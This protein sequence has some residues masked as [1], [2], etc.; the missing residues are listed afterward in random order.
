MNSEKWTKELKPVHCHYFECS[1]NEEWTTYKLQ[2]YEEVTVAIPIRVTNDMNESLDR[3]FTRKEVVTALKQVHPTIAPGPDG[4]FALFYQK[5]WNIVG[6][7]ITNMVLNVLNNNVSMAEL[8]KTNIS[9]IPKTNSPKRMIDF[10]PPLSAYVMWC[11]S[12]FQK[13]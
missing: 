11:I 7:G 3:V 12:S 5:Y 13:H 2:D 4:M 1:H 10:C 9:L 6:N 8:N